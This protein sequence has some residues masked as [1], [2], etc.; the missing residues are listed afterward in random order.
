MEKYSNVYVET[1]SDGSIYVGIQFDKATP[2]AYAV[3]RPDGT[4]QLLEGF[5]KDNDQVSGAIENA[6]GTLSGI[7][8]QLQE[9]AT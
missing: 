4:R 3:F 2:R 1:F 8:Q 5:P 6:I 7:L 9:Y